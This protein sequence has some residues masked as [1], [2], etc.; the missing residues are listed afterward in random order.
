MM[1][2]LSWFKPSNTYLMAT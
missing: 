1:N 2:H